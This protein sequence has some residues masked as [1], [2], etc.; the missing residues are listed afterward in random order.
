MNQ[1]RMNRKPSAV[2]PPQA[3]PD[4]DNRLAPTTG[5]MVAHDAMVA[6]ALERNQRLLKEL[7]KEEVAVLLRHLDRLTDAAARM[8]DAEKDLN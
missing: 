4:Q 3:D 5:M 8:L 2:V 7:G 1:K 6:G